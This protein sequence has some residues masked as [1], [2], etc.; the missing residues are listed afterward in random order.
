[1][2]NQMLEQAKNAVNRMMNGGTF[3][4]EDKRAA[5]SAIQAAYSH[6][7]TEEQQELRQLEEQLQK[8]N[9]WK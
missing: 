7:T 8:D 5:Q 2:K 4:E 9:N 6:A 3:D 1:M